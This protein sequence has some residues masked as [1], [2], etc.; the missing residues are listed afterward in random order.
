M[1]GDGAEGGEYQ[2]ASALWGQVSFQGDRNRT[3]IDRDITWMN[4]GDAGE[5]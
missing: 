4:D 2:G 1:G 5:P 3:A